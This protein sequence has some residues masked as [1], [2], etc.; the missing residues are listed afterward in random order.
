MCPP[1]RASVLSAWAWPRP[2]FSVA[3]RYLHQHPDIAP[4]LHKLLQEDRHFSKLDVKPSDLLWNK[5]AATFPSFIRTIVGQQISTKAAASIYNRLHDRLQGEVTPDAF[6]SLSEED[7]R[8]CG[9]SFGKIKYGQGLA[10]AI[11]TKEFSPHRLRHMNDEDVIADI[12]RLQGFGVW[13]AQMVLMFSLARPDVWPVGDLGIQLGAQSY[14]RL[15]EK[16]DLKTVQKLGD[17]WKGHRSAASLLLWHVA[18]NK[19]KL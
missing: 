3:V 5:R 16:P 13:S 11:L 4:G 6:L 14:L 10:N 12:V 8:L 15:R 9:F 1:L 17:R 19:I 18:N 7:L 2:D